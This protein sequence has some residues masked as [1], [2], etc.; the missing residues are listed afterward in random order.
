MAW[1]NEYNKIVEDMI[2]GIT[3]E[4][5][6]NKIYMDPA[7]GSDGGDG[8]RQSPVKTIAAG[9]GMLRDGYNDILYWVPGA[10]YVDLTAAFTWA[11]S[12]THF[13][14]LAGPGVYGGRCRLRDIA[15]ISDPLF[16][17]TG[18]GNI[19]KAI[20]WQRDFDSALGLQNVT[21]GTNAS[22]NY[23]EDCQFDSPIMASLGAAVYKNLVLGDGARSNT[24]R[25]CTI[26]QW[27]QTA[28]G[29]SGCQI[30][31]VGGTNGNAG[32]HFMDCTVLWNTSSAS[33]VPIQITDLIVSY[34]Y[35]LFDRCKF[36]GLGTSVNDLCSVPTTGK[37]IF[38]DPRGMGFGLYS[39]T[40]SNKVWVCAPVTAGD[41]Q[42]GIGVAV[43]S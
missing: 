31:G 39:A 14:G 28:S 3:G 13:I 23:F 22:Y 33:M 24:F 7:K 25:R 1:R 15:V 36:L 6:G 37:I 29:A 35:V 21:L 8:S 34:A 5:P 43:T 9:Y 42:G 17:I 41:D 11:K 30:Y 16:S 12:F 26:G 40:S 32:T 38:L 20:H 4:L 19:F 27:N 18:I 10:S 2:L